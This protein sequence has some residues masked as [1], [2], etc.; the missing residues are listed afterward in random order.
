METD[1]HRYLHHQSGD[2]EC[3]IR[4]SG[5]DWQRPDAQ[6]TQRL[7][8]VIALGYIG[9]G[10]PQELRQRWSQGS[11]NVGHGR[12]M[13]DGDR[14]HGPEEKLRYLVV[15]IWRLG[16]IQQ[17]LE[18]VVI[19]EESD[20]SLAGI[21]TEV[22]KGSLHVEQLLDLFRR[23]HDIVDPLRW[24]SCRTSHVPFS[25]ALQVQ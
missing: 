19:V 24:F 23:Q 22:S 5:A 12:I 16:R 20:S 4:R 25:T 2:H 17:W 14:Y 10:C 11:E 15:I 21:R 13:S 7:D 1:L 9:N 3:R 18:R 8:D 6:H